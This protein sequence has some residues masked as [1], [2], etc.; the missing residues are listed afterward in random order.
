MGLLIK[1][2]FDTIIRFINRS[3][4]YKFV[5]TFQRGK[6]SLNNDLKTTYFEFV[7]VFGKKKFV[8]FLRKIT[9]F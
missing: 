7:F 1:F 9:I 2:L 6:Y 3:Y 5:N 8:T 4:L